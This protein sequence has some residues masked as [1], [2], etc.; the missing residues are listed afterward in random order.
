MVS[1]NPI[2]QE[3]SAPCGVPP[4]PAH[5]PAYDFIRREA[6]MVQRAQ[7]YLRGQAGQVAQD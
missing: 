5:H 4:C 7:A 6:L 2:L 3:I 1:K